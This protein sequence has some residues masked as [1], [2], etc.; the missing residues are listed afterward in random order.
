MTTKFY[1]LLTNQGAAKLANAAALGT[2][3]QITE[4]AV[5]DGNG[6]LPTPDASQTRLVNEKRRAALNSLSVDAVN[7]S[8]IIAEQVIPENEGGFWIREIGLFDADGDMVAVANCAETY[9]PQLQEGSGRTQ[10]IRMILIVNSTAA[11]TL[12]IDPSV[13]L[14]TRKYVDDKVIEVRAYADGVMET[15]LA[16]KNP[17][18][19]YLQIASALA[20]IKD[21]GLVADVLKNLGLGEAAKKDVGTEANQLPDMSSFGRSLASNGYQKLPG[22]LII[23]WGFTATG[24]TGNTVT[25]P[26]AF[27]N[28]VAGCAGNEAGDDTSIKV[29]SVIPKSL[30]TL[31]ISGR[32]VGSNTLANTVVRWIAIGY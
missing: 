8:Q 31:K 26:V 5:G 17:H 32:V 16:Q 24:S 25:L 28:W 21:A 12:K 30:S 19:Q 14:A 1:A 15:H 23:Q 18:A 13:V 7:S 3:I 20:E 9:K 11:V 22:G 29:V 27:N 2:K 10:T 4:M 6:S